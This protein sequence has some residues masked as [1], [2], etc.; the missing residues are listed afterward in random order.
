M[1]PLGLAIPIGR[2]VGLLLRTVAVTVQKWAV[3]PESAMATESGG[4][5]V[6]GGPTCTEDKHKP[7]SLETLIGIRGSGVGT[8]GSPRRQVD[9][10][11]GRR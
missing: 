5:M 6:G 8:I 2:V 7:E 1:L 3:L 10:D 4:T 11:A 9:G